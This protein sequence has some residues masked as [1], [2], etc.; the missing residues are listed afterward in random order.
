MTPWSWVKPLPTDTFTV[1]I[2]FCFRDTH[3]V[4]KQVSFGQQCSSFP[5][6]RE[7]TAN[8]SNKRR[9]KPR[10][11]R[12]TNAMNKQANKKNYNESMIGLKVTPKS[13]A[14]Q[15][16]R[17]VF[18]PFDDRP[19]D[20]SKS[21]KAKVKIQKARSSL[22]DFFIASRKP[23]V[24]QLKCSV[25]K[26]DGWDWYGFMPPPPPPPVKK[27]PLKNNR[28]QNTYLNILGILG[29]N[30][31]TS[32]PGLGKNLKWLPEMAFQGFQISTFSGGACPQTPPPP[33]R[34]WRLRRASSYGYGIIRVDRRKEVS[35]RWETFKSF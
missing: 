13:T 16:I 4:P 7:G 3:L 12:L 23:R 35:M 11:R 5:C 14:S 32:L 30:V 26:I 34:D 27:P 6:V 24:A 28:N 15:I 33:P 10:Q 22:I 9:Q 19:A 25:L 1:F 2:V 29:M 17:K 21:H 20:R 8:N 18:E 31:K